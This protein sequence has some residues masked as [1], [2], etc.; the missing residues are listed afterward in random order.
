MRTF[1]WHKRPESGESSTRGSPPPQG[2]TAQAV[3]S[4]QSDLSGIQGAGSLARCG[5]TIGGKLPPMVAQQPRGAQYRVDHCVLRPAGSAQI[6]LT[7]SS[8]TA[9]CG[10][11][12]RVVWQGCLLPEAP[13]AAYPDCCRRGP[14][15]RAQAPQAVRAARRPK[16][17]AS[18]NPPA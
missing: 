18:A 16:V 5:P 10:P 12:C 8:R 9:R 13:D 7:S 14:A 11:A 15:G 17:S 1:G 2:H 6:V 4:V 3:E